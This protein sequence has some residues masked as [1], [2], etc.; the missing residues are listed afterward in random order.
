MTQQEFEILMDKARNFN[1]EIDED[2]ASQ[3][4]LRLCESAPSEQ[5]ATVCQAIED[6]ILLADWELVAQGLAMLQGIQA[7]VKSAE[8]SLKATS[9]N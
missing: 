6:G 8:E 7:V 3:G 2:D 9:N 1:R 4:F 5:L